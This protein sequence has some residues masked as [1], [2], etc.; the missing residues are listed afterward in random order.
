MANVSINFVMKATYASRPF[1]SPLLPLD[2]YPSPHGSTPERTTVVKRWLLSIILC[3]GTSTTGSRFRERSR[4]STIF[5]R[6]NRQVNPRRSPGK[7]HND[8]R[9]QVGGRTQADS[10]WEC[11]VPQIAIYRPAPDKDTGA[12]VVICPGGA[13]TSWRMTWKGPKS[14]T[15]STELVSP[16][17]SSSIAFQRE[18][19]SDA[20]GP[21]SKTRSGRS[22]W[23]ERMPK[24]ES[25]IRIES[26]ICGFS[27]GGETAARRPPCFETG[28][29]S[30]SMKTIE[31]R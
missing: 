7:R 29:M 25:S 12:S 21:P 1:S 17:S 20:I 3:L 15:G 5:G 18:R 26:A 6:R 22:A 28:R 2:R 24:M 19:Q 13:T 8:R 10:S 16:A 31:P 30:L 9:R 4:S 27:A 14:P 11:L 23:F